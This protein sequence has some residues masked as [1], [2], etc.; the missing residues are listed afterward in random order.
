MKSSFFLY[1]ACK[2][3]NVI[4]AEPVIRSSNDLRAAMAHT[5]IRNEHMCNGSVVLAKTTWLCARAY[6]AL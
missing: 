1:E 5:H 4:V 3:V 6:A 2:Q